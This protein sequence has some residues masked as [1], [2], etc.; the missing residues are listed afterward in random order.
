VRVLRTCIFPLLVTWLG[1][2]QRGR[3][4]Y[5]IYLHLKDSWA[6]Y[7]WAGIGIGVLYGWESYSEV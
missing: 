2:I 4:L 1:H 3:H 7:R 6:T 5:P